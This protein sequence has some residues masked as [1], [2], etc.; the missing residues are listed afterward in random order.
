MTKA[1]LI[2]VS[3][4]FSLVTLTISSD[5]DEPAHKSTPEPSSLRNKDLSQEMDE[6]G[7]DISPF[8]NAMKPTSFGKS[9][10]ERMEDEASFFSCFSC[11]T[12]SVLRGGW[13]R[14]VLLQY[15]SVEIEFPCIFFS[16]RT[17]LSKSCR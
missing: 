5:E 15:F 6:D 8:V 17:M 13:K 11:V 1:A 9:R 16:G 4:L 14:L 10:R 3:F 2:F 12:F 7:L